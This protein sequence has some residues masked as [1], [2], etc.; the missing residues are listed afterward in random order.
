MNGN[1]TIIEINGIPD[2]ANITCLA[3]GETDTDVLII[4]VLPGG[5]VVIRNG[6][7]SKDGK[8]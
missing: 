3:G 5:G 6:T 7:D 8:I 4:E 1:L 2:G